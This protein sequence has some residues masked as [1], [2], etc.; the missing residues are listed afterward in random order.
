MIKVAH[1]TRKP[2]PLGNFS[3]ET[4]FGIIREQLRDKVSIEVIQSRYLSNGLLKRIYN[5]IEAALHQKDVNHVL[6]DVTFLAT[7]LKKC[8]TITT[9]LDCNVLATSSGIK[10]KIIKFFW[11][12]IPVLRSGYITTISDATR[13]ELIKYTGCPSEKIRVIYVSISEK[14]QQNEKP[15]NSRIPSILQ[16]GTAPNKNINR[17]VE[18]IRE[19]PCRLTIIGKVDDELKAKLKDY[20]IQH[21]LVE[22]HLTE[23]EVITY[24][25]QCDIVSFV[26]TYEGFGMPIVEANAI[27]RCVITGNTTSMPEVAANAACVVDPFSISEIADGLKKII[28]NNVYRAELINN[29][30]KNAER[31][32]KKVIA[33]QFLNLYTEVYNKR[34]N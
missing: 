21:L 5:S 17:L 9:F 32:N 1:F 22:T 34:L 30:Y 27:G 18:A 31:F 15:F 7:F 33:E 29:G 10:H 3:I 20:N 8:K 23:E 12:K 4:Y 26:S 11:F 14:F 28:N 16:I 6:G 24:Y 2:R 13:Q 19:I 25:Q